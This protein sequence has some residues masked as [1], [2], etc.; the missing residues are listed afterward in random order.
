LWSAVEIVKVFPEG[1]PQA[2]AAGGFEGQ[3]G[4][5]DLQRGFRPGGGRT[6]GWPPRHDSLAI[7]R[8]IRHATG[9]EGLCTYEECFEESP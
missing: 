3:A 8:T 6:F 2:P 1:D 5:I 4:R 7:L 9:V